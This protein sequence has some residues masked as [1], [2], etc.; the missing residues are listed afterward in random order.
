M[1]INTVRLIATILT[2]STATAFAGGYDATGPVEAPPAQT[3]FPTGWYVSLNAGASLIQNITKNNHKHSGFVS[4]AAA[5]YG[6]F[7][8]DENWAAELGAAYNSMGSFGHYAIFDAAVKASVPMTTF[9]TVFVKLGGAA[10]T[11][12]ACDGGCQTETKGAPFFAGGIGVLLRYNIMA[13]VEYDGVYVSSGSV[14]GTLGTLSA[15]LIYY[16]GC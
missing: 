3:G 4:Y 5:A 14:D 15:G 13:T 16:F 1:N 6:G 12:K 2:L 9:S 8:Y 11:Y 10:V 7:Q